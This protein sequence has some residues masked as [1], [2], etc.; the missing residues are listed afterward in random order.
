MRNH[1]VLGATAGAALAVGAG[2]TL[3]TAAGRRLRRQLV[4][5]VMRRARYERGRIQGVRY[6]MAGRHPDEH[7]ESR[8][9][10]DR[11]RSVLGPLEHRLDVPRIHVMADGHHVLLHGDVA[12][13]DQAETLVDA[14]RSVPGVEQVDSH[15]HVGLFSGDTRPSEGGD[16]HPPSPALAAVLAAARGAGTPKGSERFTTR[17]VLSTFASQL[18][19]GERRHLLSHLPED[20]RVLAETPI[21]TSSGQPH[22]RHLDEF[23]AAVGLPPAERGHE[24]EIIGSVLGAVRTLVPEEAAGVAAVLPSELRTFWTTAAAR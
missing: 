14:V 1:R 9:L 5:A 6:R 18:P 21:P 13:D 15:L 12:S 22:L 3:Q 16:H 4:R 11:V 24:Q 2:M 8:Q 19:P 7:A 10:A 17:A 20:L 23:V